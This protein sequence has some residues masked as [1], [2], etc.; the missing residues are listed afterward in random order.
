MCPLN[1]KKLYV[2][3]ATNW[4]SVNIKEILGRKAYKEHHPK[5]E[6]KDSY[7]KISALNSVRPFVIPLNIV[8]LSQR[9]ISRHCT[10]VCFFTVFQQIHFKEP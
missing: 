6:G 3:L 4:Y 5:T 10:R 9:E 1:K 7:I 2:K 8:K